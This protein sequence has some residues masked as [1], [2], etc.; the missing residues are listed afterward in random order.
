MYDGVGGVFGPRPNGCGR[1]GVTNGVIFT[2]EM[3][4]RIE[5]IIEVIDFDYCWAFHY[6]CAFIGGGCFP[7]LVVDEAALECALFYFACGGVEFANPKEITVV[8]AHVVEIAAPVGIGEQEG[9]D[10]FSEP[11]MG[12]GS[13]CV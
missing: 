10:I 12:S 6:R 8:E 4:G 5:Q 7:W 9:V 13:A 2:H 11:S 3:V 1:C